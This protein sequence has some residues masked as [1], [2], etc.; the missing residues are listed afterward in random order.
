MNVKRFAEEELMRY[1]AKEFNI[2]RRHISS[3]GTRDLSVEEWKELFFNLKEKILS[4]IKK[5]EIDT[6]QKIKEYFEKLSIEW[7]NYAFKN[8]WREALNYKKREVKNLI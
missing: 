8:S 6:E 7:A 4:D 5:A 3:P 1:F 2:A